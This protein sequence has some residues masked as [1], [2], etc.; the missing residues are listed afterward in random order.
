MRLRVTSIAG[1][2]SDRCPIGLLTSPLP[3]SMIY[4]QTTAG[5]W[6]VRAP[7]RFSAR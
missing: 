4:P 3:R 2:S 6:I 1:I 7:R 5:Q